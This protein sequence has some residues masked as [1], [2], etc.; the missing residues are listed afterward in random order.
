MKT[1]EMS[2]RIFGWLVTLLLS[3]GCLAAEPILVNSDWLA[4]RLDDPQIVLIDMTLDPY[5]YRRFHLPGARYLPPSA[6]T[7]KNE[8]GVKVRTS[9]RQLYRLLGQ[10]GITADSHVVDRTPGSEPRLMWESE[11]IKRLPGRIP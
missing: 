11:H 4:S 10:L 7:R 2:L 6:L 1:L 5:Q 8:M 9:D 3:A